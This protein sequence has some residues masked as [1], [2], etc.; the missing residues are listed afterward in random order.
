MILTGVKI[1]E[2]VKANHILL[3]PFDENM[4]NPNSY[5][6][7]LGDELL[8]L[9]DDI[10]NPLKKSNYKRIKLTEEGYVLKPHCLYL[11]ST[12]EKIGSDKYVTQ[13]I[14]RSS[15]GR[16]GLFLQVTAPLGHVGCGHCWTLELKAVQPIRV[17]PNMRIGQV[18][19]WV[20]DG[21]PMYTYQTGKYNGYSKPHISTFYKKGVNK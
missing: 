8:E 17:Y 10:I 1:K 3:D 2:E 7:H 21:N 19:F 16:L 14:G 9:T 5:N 20:L 6:Y 12:V 18:T 4:L 11:G 13:L 15:V